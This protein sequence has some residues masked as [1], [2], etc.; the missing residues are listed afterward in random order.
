ML[1]W[2]DLWNKD[3]A[4][5]FAANFVISGIVVGLVATLIQN[6][7]AT[8]VAGFVYGI[9]PFSF[10]YLYAFTWITKGAAH[11][12]PFAWYAAVGGAFWLCFVGVTGFASVVLARIPE[13]LPA[14]GANV[15]SLG[16]GLG[17]TALATWAY[18]AH[19]SLD[20]A[21]PPAAAARATT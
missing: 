2:R 10:L 19:V 14:W 16:M 4:R 9:V 18:L 17:V 3:F 15:A 13:R 6:L 12:P 5:Q 1:A 21:P 20:A 7:D 11:V 8:K